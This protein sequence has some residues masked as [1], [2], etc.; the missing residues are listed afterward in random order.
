MMKAK[1]MSP[2]AGVVAL[3]IILLTGYQPVIAAP[4]AGEVTTVVPLLGNETPI[5]YLEDGQ[6]N[7][8]IQLLYDPLVGTTPD[9]RLSTEN[10]LANKWEMSPD[11]LTWTFYLRRGVK[12]HDGVEVTAKDVSSVSISCCSLTLRL[13]TRSSL[14]RV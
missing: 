2:L 7:D 1:L 14:S 9:G 12:F 11:G 6:G 10:G 8:Y 4:P 3:M 5:P 13:L